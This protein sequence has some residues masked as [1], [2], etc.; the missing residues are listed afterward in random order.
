M[1]ISAV[2][3]ESSVLLYEF[4]VLLMKLYIDVYV[5]VGFAFARN[6]A[7]EDKDLLSR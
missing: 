6:S 1:E 7:L 4:P 5:T 3:P 2:T